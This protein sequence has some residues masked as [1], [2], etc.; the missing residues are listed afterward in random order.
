[1]RKLYIDD[2]LWDPASGGAW[3][4]IIKTLKKIQQL[5]VLAIFFHP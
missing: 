4:S 3:F 1:M 2:A 5:F